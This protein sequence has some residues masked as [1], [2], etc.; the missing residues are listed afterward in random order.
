MKPKAGKSEERTCPAIGVMTEIN[1][2]ATPVRRQTCE[3]ELQYGEV[4][5]ICF[6][7]SCINE[8]D[9][10]YEVRRQYV[11]FQVTPKGE[12]SEP[13]GRSF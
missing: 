10:N 7:Q 4:K 12:R 13:E 5:R 8:A 2:A 6:S 9:C 11:A 1:E 3:V